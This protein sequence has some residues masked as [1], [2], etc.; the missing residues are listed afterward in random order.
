MKTPH[1][2]ALLF[3]AAVS[4][5][6]AVAVAPAPPEA[7]FQVGPPPVHGFQAGAPRFEPDCKDV[8]FQPE[9]SAVS[10]PVTLTSQQWVTDCAPSGA[11]GTSCWEHQGFSDS[12]LVHLTL[13]DRKPLLPWE[14]DVF[15]VC[16]SGPAL[17]TIPVSTA[18]DYTVIRDG[19]GDGNVLLSAGAK[20]PLPPDPRGV[21][22]VLTPGLTL[23]L[24]D[25]WET[26]YPGGEITL[27]ITLMKEVRFWPD[28]AVAQKE[29]TLPVASNYYV[30]FDNA[31]ANPTGIY[32]ARYSVIRRGGT[33][34]TEAETVPLTTERVGYDRDVR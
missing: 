10:K 22:A 5:S 16:L 21:Q 28:Q 3:A 17:T 33:V 14:S 7:P 1:V 20:H 30:E 13:G 15:R 23:A 18:Y 27:K 29:I 32:Y 6:A 31:V 9:D 11:A 2:V 8:V 19:A 12:L 24:S 26:Y 4:A 34:S 25:R